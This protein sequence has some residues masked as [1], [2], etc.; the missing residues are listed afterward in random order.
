MYTVTCDSQNVIRKDI[1]YQ[2]FLPFEILFVSP[3]LLYSDVINYLKN[4]CF[5]PG[6]WGMN[7]SGEQTNCVNREGRFAWSRIRLIPHWPW[8]KNS[9]LTSTMLPAKTFPKIY[10]EELL[11]QNL[12]I[13]CI[14]GKGPC[15]I[16]H[17]VGTG[18][19]CDG[20]SIFY[21]HL[22]LDEE[23]FR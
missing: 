20:T 21:D 13:W 22:A 12:F 23:I 16:Y 10:R 5:F 7:R 1:Y 14:L 19:K 8:Y 4:E 17:R 15:N 3:L 6:S 18:A 9:F 11:I 2:F